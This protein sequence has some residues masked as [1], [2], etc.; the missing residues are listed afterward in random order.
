MKGMGI[1]MKKKTRKLSIRTKILLL[2][3]ILI[4]LVCL[5]IG[6]SSFLQIKSNMVLMGVE[7]ADMASNIAIQMVDGD[8]LSVIRPGD[9]GTDEYNKTLN[10]LRNARDI[11]GIEFLYTLYTDGQTVYY[12][13]DTD[14][15][16]GHAAIGKVFDASYDELSGVFAGNEYVQ[17]YIDSTDDGNLI[18]CYKPI[19]D[20]D[21]NVVAV[22]GSDYN[23]DTIID[24][25]D[26]ARNSVILLMLISLFVAILVLNII[27]GSLARSLRTVDK[28]IYELVNNGGDL[29]KKLDI[30]SGDEMELISNHIND[31]LEYIRGIILNI[32]NYSK[33]IDN[34]ASSIAD[35]LTSAGEMIIDVSAIMEEMTGTMTNTSESLNDINMSV[36]NVYDSVENIAHD[37]AEK[38]KELGRI[39]ERALTVHSEAEVSRD[40][41]KG[42]EKSIVDAIR[43]K[44]IK[45]KAVEEITTLTENILHITEETNLLAL[46]ASIEA[47]RAGEAGRGFAVVA[48]EIGNLASSS[49]EAASKIQLVSDEVIK[50]VNELAEE[51]EIM[52]EFMD[53]TAMEGYDKL[54]DLSVNYQSETEKLN[55]MM[56]DLTD[57]SAN[58][59]VNMDSIREAVSNVATAVE[60]STAGIETVTQRA[61]DLTGSVNSI[62]EDANANKNIVTCLNTEVGKFKV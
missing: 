60:Q 9:E 48:G 43:E 11:C 41:V 57:Q 32:V 27:V 53:K 23:A 17:D 19:L 49:A 4:V 15:T 2:S 51:A 56:A 33:T 42:K 26:K 28:K 58:L 47:A 52:A 18:S 22:L 7:E 45:S 55:Q 34:S 38:Q 29:T 36:S 37:A 10:V 46:N 5:F 16:D 6:I 12:G 21:G 35:S 62:E 1:K 50:A 8:M 24:R 59:R 20:S 54:I 44:I 31:L 39:S 40:D 30:T 14:E 25:L 13:V 3:G 61:V